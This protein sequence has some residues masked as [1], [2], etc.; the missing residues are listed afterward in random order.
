MSLDKLNFNNESKK[1]LEGLKPW[2]E[3]H[4]DFKRI[5]VVTHGGYIMEFYN[6]MKQLNGQK[7]SNSNCAKNCAV[8]VF[9]VEQKPDMSPEEMSPNEGKHLLSIFI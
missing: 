4:E 8:Y 3:K 6:L 5:L 1:I 2:E 7:V 9:G